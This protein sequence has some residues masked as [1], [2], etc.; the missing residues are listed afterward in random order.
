MF[1]KVGSVVFQCLDPQGLLSAL[2]WRLRGVPVYARAFRYLPKGVVDLAGIKPLSVD[3]RP[4]VK[5]VRLALVESVFHL[6]LEETRHVAWS[7]RLFGSKDIDQAFK[8]RILEELED[9][10]VTIGGI[11]NGGVFSQ[12]VIL[13]SGCS[14]LPVGF[15]SLVHEGR[16]PQEALDQVEL[17]HQ[18]VIRRLRVVRPS[19]LLGLI[20]LLLEVGI[21][22][23]FVLKRLRWRLRPREQFHLAIRSYLT[24][25]GF[26]L[27]GM[28]RMRNVDFLVDGKDFHTG[29]TIFW[30]EDAV[31]EDQ[32]KMGK[33]KERGY[34]YAFPSRLVYDRRC[35]WRVALPALRSYIGYRLFA[36]TRDLFET[37]TC[38]GLWKSCLL[39]WTFAEYFHPRYLV[40]YNDVGFNSTARNI[41]LRATGCHSVFYPHSYN[42]AIDSTGY[43]R[44]HPW[45]SFLYYD[46]LASWGKLQADYYRSGG[47]RYGE[48]LNLGCL[49]SE[50]AQLIQQ[51]EGLRRKYEAE[52]VSV[53]SVSPNRFHRRVAVFDTSVSSMLS[54][55]DLS[56]FYEGIIRLSQRLKNVLFL[57]RPKYPVKELFAQAGETG[58]QLSKEMHSASNIVF[59]PD[60]F[61]TA[62]AIGLTDL[63]ISA[64][65][66][67]TTVE[68]IGCGKRAVYYNPTNRMPQAFWCRI[69]DMVCVS[70]EEFHERV[71]YLLYECDDKTYMDYLRTHFMGIEGHFDGGGI[72]RLRQRLLDVMNDRQSGIETHG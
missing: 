37:R 40:V 11:T 28:P 6:L 1:Q 41:A 53:A 42:W 54:V 21:S 27:G 46:I 23:W 12:G 45:I 13:L 57:C 38:R 51:D 67:S 69:P 44:P 24:D 32:H 30:L 48:S 16:L 22:C 60:Y 9:F 50:H 14:N 39:A 19:R 71:H 36:G 15:V 8:R 18:E 62:A 35:A 43:W 5:K 33:L 26:D 3:T 34:R 47:G 17:S 66:T 31:Q 7:R 56:G 58:D 64:C 61:E 49:W 63:T 20:R 68:A 10:F 72:T 25:W 55:H 65:F 29:N 52:L 70:D 2:S 4:S 59:L